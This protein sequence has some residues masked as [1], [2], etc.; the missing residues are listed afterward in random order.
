METLSILVGLIINKIEEVYDYVQITFSDGSIL[1]IF[2]NYYYDGN[3]VFDL[4]GKEIKSI[5]NLDNGI[6]IIFE[7]NESFMIGISDDDYNGP[8]AMTLKKEG[9]TPI[10]W[11]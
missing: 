5:E 8:E 7:N 3:T 6:N 4:K 11:N 10:V 9:Q 1:S 2:N